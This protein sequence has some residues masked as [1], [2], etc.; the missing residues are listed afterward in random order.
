MVYILLLGSEWITSYTNSTKNEAANCT[1]NNPHAK[2]NNYPHIS[3]RDQQHSRKSSSCK[4][5]MDLNN[6]TNS[7]MAI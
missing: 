4:Q 6:Y 7:V 3:P 1:K 2:D 5:A